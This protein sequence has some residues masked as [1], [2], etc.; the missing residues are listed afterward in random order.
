MRG[1]TGVLEGFEEAGIASYGE[2]HL[3]QLLRLG[4]LTPDIVF[5]IVDGCQQVDLTGRRLLRAANLPLDWAGQ[6]EILG[7]A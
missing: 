7:F 5:A 1:I 4:W 2:R 3:W 6:R